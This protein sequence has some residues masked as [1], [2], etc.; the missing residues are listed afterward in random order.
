MNEKLDQRNVNVVSGLFIDLS[1]AFDTVNH[2]LL[3]KLHCAGIRGNVLN[4]FQSYLSNRK[5][6]VTLDK[7]PSEIK[8]ITAGVPQGLVLGPTDS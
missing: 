4:L 7:V 1:K 5:Q 2:L 8:A 6:L 3:R